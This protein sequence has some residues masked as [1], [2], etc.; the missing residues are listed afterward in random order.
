ME[1]LILEDGRFDYI[2]S[3]SL[4]G[5]R[6]KDVTPYPVGFEQILPMYPLD[7]EEYLW[8][9]GIQNHTLQYLKS[10]YDKKYLRQY[11]RHFAN[12]FTVI[13]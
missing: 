3:G 8:A 13:L 9:N 5:V 1:I 2:E 7:F 12:F 10:C 4:L 6:Y 11:M